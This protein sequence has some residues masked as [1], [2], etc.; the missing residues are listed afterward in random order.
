MSGL[1]A[2][3]A[4]P[5]GWGVYVG[6]AFQSIVATA[7]A[8]SASV[9]ARK[10]RLRGERLGRLLLGDLRG[11]SGVTTGGGVGGASVG[12]VSTLRGAGVGVVWVGASTLSGA[13]FCGG[14]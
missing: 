1:T 2:F 10:D 4:Y 7:S 14:G 3:M 5:F 9:A 8:M 6:S 12:V 13:S 11:F